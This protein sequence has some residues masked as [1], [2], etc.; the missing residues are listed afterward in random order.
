MAD[1]W[2][3]Y[4]QSIQPLSLDD[5]TVQRTTES[6]ETLSQ[7]SK[8]FTGCHDF[9]GIVASQEAP[10]S[11]P[12]FNK[13]YCSSPSIENSRSDCAYERYNDSQW[14]D[15]GKQL[16]NDYL[17]GCGKNYFPTEV[18]SE[19][20]SNTSDC[21]G[22]EQNCEILPTSC[23]ENYSSVS[24]SSNTDAV[25][26][27]PSC[28]VTGSDSF[29]RQNIEMLSEE[30][31]EL[32]F[33]DTENCDSQTNCVYPN[34]SEKI[35]FSIKTCAENAESSAT[36]L[37]T[38]TVSE[39]VHNGFQGD[40]QNEAV[41]RDFKEGTFK[42]CLT[43]NLTK[44]GIDHDPLDKEEEEGIDHDPLDKEEDDQIKSTTPTLFDN[45]QA[46]VDEKVLKKTGIDS[47]ESS[48]LGLSDDQETIASEN[49]QGNTQVQDCLTK[50][51]DSS[52]PK[53]FDEEI[54]LTS[55]STKSG[56]DTEKRET[57][58]KVS[59]T[60]D[61]LDLK[62]SSFKGICDEMS[63]CN[64]NI[65]HHN[66]DSSFHKKQF[67]HC[68]PAQDSISAI[69]SEVE[70]DHFKD[71]TIVTFPESHLQ[72]IKD[73]SNIHTE[74]EIK[75]D[76]EFTIASGTD[77]DLDC[78]VSDT[79]NLSSS[80]DE[81]KKNVAY[82]ELSNLK[83]QSSGPDENPQKDGFPNAVKSTDL[84]PN[85]DCV[86]PIVTDDISYENTGSKNHQDTII[87]K[88]SASET[89]C[90]SKYI[91]SSAE[92]KSSSLDKMTTN[93]SLCCH[94]P[95]ATSDSL[96][97]DNNNEN[98]S[99]ASN[100]DS[101]VKPNV[102]GTHSPNCLKMG[103]PPKTDTRSLSPNECGDPIATFDR[104]S[105]VSKDV[106]SPE[107]LL[108]PDSSNTDL[109][110]CLSNECASPAKRT[111]TSFQKDSM[112]DTQSVTFDN[113]QRI[114][115]IK[116]FSE[117][118]QVCPKEN[119]NMI[120]FPTHRESQHESFIAQEPIS[121]CSDVDDNTR[122]SFEDWDFSIQ[123]QSESSLLYGEPL[124]E[125]SLCDADEENFKSSQQ[126]ETK[127]K[128]PNEYNKDQTEQ[129]ALPLTHSVQTRR[130][131][132]PVVLLA[133]SESSNEMSNSY[134]CADCQHTS[135][136]IDHL[137][138]H[139]HC[140]H[141]MSVFH[142][143]K[144]C[145]VYL[146]RNKLNQKHVCDVV[147][148]STPLSSNSIP[149]KKRRLTAPHN[150]TRC[151]IVFSKLI[152]YVKHM[153]THTGKTPY[154]CNECGLYF[155]QSCSLRKHKRVP[156][157]CKQYKLLN[158]NSDAGKTEKS[159]EKQKPQNF[160]N[161]NT[162][163]CYVKLID[164]SKFNLCH[165][166]GKEFVSAKRVKKHIHD[167]H[168]YKGGAIS[169]NVA[170][171]NDDG[172]PQEVKGEMQEKYKCPLCPRLFKYP[173]NRNRHL[174]DC[175]KI[176]VAGNKNK[177]GDK[178]ACPLCKATFTASGNRR[179]HIKC[180]CLRQCII[181]FRKER[182]IVLQKTRKMDLEPQSKDME[183]TPATESVPK[184]SSVLTAS[185]I[186]PLYRCNHCPAVFRD[187]SGKY[188]HMKKH[189]MFKLTGKM[190]K[191]RN[192]VFSVAPKLETQNSTT[193]DSTELSETVEEKSSLICRFC[194][195]G[196]VHLTTLK[197]HE[198]SHRGE[199]PYRCLE[200]GKGFKKRAHLTGHKIVHQKRMQ[201]TICSKI[202][203]TVGELL[204]HR[205]LH[206]KRGRLQCPD[207]PTQFDYPAHLLRHLK[208]HRKKEKKLQQPEEGTQLK[209]QEP[210]ESVKEYNAQKQQQCV[211]CK[212][213]FDDSLNLRKHTLTHISR[214]SSPRCPFCKKSYPERRN[215]LRHLIVH[216][217]DKSL[218]CTNCGKQFYRPLY[219]NIHM[220]KCLPPQANCSFETTSSTK[221]KSK[222]YHCSRCFRSFCKRDRWQK[223]LYGHKKN[224]LIPCPR[225]GQFFGRTKIT[226]HNVFCRET[227]ESSTDKCTTNVSIKNSP[228][229]S[230]IIHKTPSS[231]K[232]ST[233]NLFKCPYCAQKFRYRS[234]FLRHLVKH[235]GVQPYA[236]M[237]CDSRFRS[238]TM[239]FKH[240]EVCDGAKSTEQSKSKSEGERNMDSLREAT[241]KP[242]P[243]CEYKCKFC[244]KTF[245]KPRSLR[246]HILTHNEVNP[247]RCKNCDSCFS[248]YDH[249][250]VH[251]TR[252]KGKKTRL[253]V[254]IPKITLDDVG[255]GWQTRFNLKPLDKE[256]TFECEV[257]LKSF[258]AL[259]K[260]SR[261]FTMFHAIKP[262]KCTRCGSAFSHEKTLKTHQ[263]MKRCKK[264]TNETKAHP[265]QESNKPAEN[266]TKPLEEIRNRILLKIQP[267][268]N[269]KFKHVCAYC[270]RS[271]KHSW[272][273]N[274]H[275]RLHTGEKPFSCE[276]CDERFIRRDYVVRHHLKCVKIR[277]HKKSLC[278]RCGNF[279][280]ENEIEDH[281]KGCPIRPYS[282]KYC[283][284]K[285]SK[286]DGMLQHSLKC[287]GKLQ[288]SDILCDKCGGFFSEDELE[289]HKKSCTS[290]PSPSPASKSHPSSSLI[291]P[292]GFSCAYCSSRFLLFSQLQEHFLSTHKLE[293]LNSSISTAP[294]QQL[295]SNIPKIKEEP[296][297]DSCEKMVTDDAN[298]ICKPDTELK[299][300]T[301]PQ[302]VCSHC[303]MCFTNKAGL[304]G[305]QRVHTKDLPFKCKVCNKGFWNKTLVRNH[306]RKCRSTTSQQLEGPLKAEIE[307]AL[308]SSDFDVKHPE[309]TDALQTYEEESE[310]ES[311]HSSFG[312]LLPSSS[313][314]EKKPIQYQCSECDK[315]FTDGLMLISHLE[316][317]GREEQEKKQNA[318]LKCGK[319][320]STQGNL[321]SHMRT[322]DTSKP[323]SCKLCQQRFWTRS[324]VCD[325]YRKEHADD[326]FYC[327]VCSNVY[328]IKKS[329]VEHYRRCHPKEWQDHGYNVLQK[330][331]TNEHQS[332][333]HV[334]TTGESD[335][336]NSDSDSDSA[337]YFPC[338]VCGK[339]FPTSE[340]LEDHQLCHLGKKPHECAE[341]GKCFVL[342]TQL[343]Q[344]QRTHK[345]EFQ[346]Q[347]CGRGFVTLFA[348][349]THKHSHGRNRPHRCSKC[350]LSFTEPIH[351]AEHMSTHR[352]ESFPCDLCS[353]VFQ[354]KSSRVEHRKSH[355]MSGGN[356]TPS[357]LKGELSES[358]SGYNSE[359]RYRCGICGER[360][361]DPEE[362]SEHGC[363]EA[364]ERPYSCTECKKH[365]LHSS[366][367]KKHM[368]THQPSRS[369]GEYPCNQCNSSFSSSQNFF[370]HLKSHVDAPKEIKQGDS[371]IGHRCPVCHQCFASATELIHHFP[372]HLDN[373][374]EEDKVQLDASKSEHE[375][376]YLTSAAEFECTKCGGNFLG[377]DAYQH[378]YCSQQQQARKES[379]YS[380]PKEKTLHRPIGDEEEVDVTGDDLY[381]CVDCSMHF[382]SKSSFLAHQNEHNSNGKSF[383][384]EHCGKTFAKMRYLKKHERR[385]R[386]KD[387][388]FSA[389]E[390][391]DKRFKCVQCLE[392]FSTVQDLS[393]HMR[394]HAEKE[395]GEYRC[396]MCYKSFSKRS[397]LKQHQESHVGEVV[398]ECTECDKAFAFPHLLDEHQKTHTKPSE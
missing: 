384:C 232:E 208:S 153:R 297:D 73:G 68:C 394:L 387:L 397:L 159:P 362:L 105:M 246:H 52:D 185:K 116:P 47:V 83:A 239:L 244:T 193:E 123:K 189:E 33:D 130:L 206:L 166:C 318:C 170:T 299:A 236:C 218:S 53:P 29:S 128:R 212:E 301:S 64:L 66:H 204:Q 274:V 260:L 17:Q 57:Q 132:H 210:V 287:D 222:P 9:S 237:H 16:E 374:H 113:E 86:S 72:P 382:S 92:M 31:S 395:V 319:V 317:H 361:R 228:Q 304:T 127:V 238:E 388:P 379:K 258:P 313:I 60:F 242:P 41:M 24:S 219:L 264:P 190:F 144:N 8:N 368:N 81:Q 225:C 224:I 363:M 75:N 140:N 48:N 344:H 214:S 62:E 396:D 270:P 329:L 174:R 71:A 293:T 155:A 146:M 188:R 88:G 378:H 118:E 2:D 340:S 215:L 5:G 21:Q 278:D 152:Q 216:L 196:F 135:N 308:C 121:V 100:M 229:I 248:R 265:M 284:K 171:A 36:S 55:V 199:R 112:S 347:T 221:K 380:D 99:D 133:T 320:F 345:S 143:C 271:F 1:G 268:V 207:C 141:P 316:D 213:V 94:A 334:S 331:T 49:V 235:T 310:D 256:E 335:E 247:Y 42:D 56:D 161:D 129:P 371:I 332:S 177:V 197:K 138:E 32:F 243:D 176:A 254:R 241:Q 157:R 326:V 234:Y 115:D 259:S 179:R 106:K 289:D 290:K 182:E 77:K 101:N 341:C 338:H 180:I 67:L 84:S 328:A 302:Y 294:L 137:I 34:T 279:F 104:L 272:Q 339:T 376:K 151:G 343:Q 194:G 348:L 139:H 323:V 226:Q 240:E 398:Y 307:F 253:E 275:V 261:H 126:E 12:N 167:V 220:Q 373:T 156:G 336:D 386:L 202:F 65:C 102:S 227:A 203:Q 40:K 200:C 198:L 93:S 205:S 90:S 369:E 35:T 286:K 267:V 50:Q 262:F 134:C 231:S 96:A 298:A 160:S 322:H 325:H 163:K 149:K 184:A 285:F 393:L 20:S 110:L 392:K 330:G 147:K 372:I 358:L 191:Y 351:L 25:D 175:V 173:Y 10:V 309:S 107:L 255:R 366:H 288:S 22:L 321:D 98:I 183:N 359:F 87:H 375:K 324:A 327:Q 80:S 76:K 355:S 276:Y 74:K 312:T 295:L 315:S 252:C 352:E 377:A 263:R 250:K 70:K 201:C 145:N 162:R 192:S 273:L 27:R 23:L 186:G 181:Q 280:P 356:P 245:M 120:S 131:L 389:A 354:S 350:H 337:P 4:F 282:C 257:C 51:L 6:D 314:Q 142:H 85:A 82:H 95:D 79:T 18:P 15:G 109:H 61:H 91:D 333:S 209:P 383:R 148:K 169:S 211:L 311:S 58:E 54:S 43:A 19:S 291:P 353:K 364:K 178:F 277:E 150:C 367:L 300:D 28:K 125:D 30:N 38:A 89:Y 223:H 195:I 63:K 303:N 59:Q 187:P 391:L 122:E 349:K 172:K 97:K 13:N 390:V 230:T 117:K 296:V 114:S 111:S 69:L 305:H 357:I 370:K 233:T 45:G 158:T 306:Y 46:L 281:K 165:L 249:L 164:I 342:A 360:F 217:G 154:R 7:P 108:P 44:E 124:S 119:H 14:Q 11:H 251:H 346:C 365:F 381:M 3:P 269:K 292:K 37:T 266:V 78:G 385:H 103:S 136:N 168:K 39:A 283:R 26:E